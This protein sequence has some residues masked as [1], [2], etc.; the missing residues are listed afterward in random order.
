MIYP[1]RNN[2]INVS[3]QNTKTMNLE[4]LL[5]HYWKN[6]YPTYVNLSKK[7]IYLHGYHIH[8]HIPSIQPSN[9]TGVT[10]GRQKTQDQ[11][12]YIQAEHHTV[13][14]CNFARS[15]SSKLIN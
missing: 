15:L 9:Q 4:L 7:P 11:N 3:V 6:F 14:I 10:P 5:L 1:D 8:D 2:S 13:K 12:I